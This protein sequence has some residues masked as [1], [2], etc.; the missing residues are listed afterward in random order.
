MKIP[1]VGGEFSDGV[2][3]TGYRNLNA[4]ALLVIYGQPL[5]YYRVLLDGTAGSIES[6]AWNVDQS[7]PFH[8]FNSDEVTF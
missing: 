2:L 6:P 1:L 5:A 7:E 3:N 8:V 4:G